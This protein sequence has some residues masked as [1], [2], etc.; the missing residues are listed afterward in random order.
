MRQTNI[1]KF[2]N[3]SSEEDGMSEKTKVWRIS[4]DT[5]AVLAALGLALVIRLGV[6]KNI[7]W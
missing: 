5:W 7:P 2:H 4:L 3:N 1:E 6:V